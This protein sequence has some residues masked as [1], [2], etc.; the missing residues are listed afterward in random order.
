MKS[1]IGGYMLSN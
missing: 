1:Y